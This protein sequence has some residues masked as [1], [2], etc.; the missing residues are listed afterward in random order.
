MAKQT[1]LLAFSGG[2]DTSAIIPWLR[3]HRQADTIAYCSDLGNA[4]DAEELAKRAKQLGAVEFIF[5]DLKEK[6]VTDFVYPAVRAG[7][8]YQEIYL[9]GTS[10]GRPLI[11]E[12]L[13]HYAEKFKATQVVHGATGKGNDQMRFE[14]SIAYLA[15]QLEV[16]APWRHWKFTSRKEL[17]D[18]L[19]A[20][21]YVY[22][23]QEKRFSEDVNLFHRSCEGGTLEHLEGEIEADVLKW[24]RLDSTPGSST[25]LSLEFEKGLPIKLNGE[26]LRADELLTRLNQLAGSYGIGVVDMVEDRM[27]GLKSRGVYETPGGTVLHFAIAQLKQIC[28][29]RA[30]ARLAANLSR[31]YAELIYDGFWHSD[32][33]NSI[34]G[35]FDQASETLTGQVEVVLKPH[36]LECGGRVS[37]LSLYSSSLVSF[38]QDATQI[39]AR[40][41]GFCKM[42]AVRQT[43]QGVRRRK[44]LGHKH[45]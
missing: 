44:L 16:F 42:V 29:D 28:W 23:D 27:V 30:T 33:R 10:L 12:R 6:F 39:N 35:F 45:K 15:P 1:V 13:V 31:E 14:N 2:L 9:L 37:D 7:A 38:E 24:T 18:Y 17:V 22:Q 8:K 21:N 20:H 11:A 4:P 43:Q 5:E 25:K 41:D 32:A 36:A 40:A 26:K 19:A 34:E 3:E